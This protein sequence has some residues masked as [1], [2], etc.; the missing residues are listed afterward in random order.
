M[1]TYWLVGTIPSRGGRPRCRRP[2][3]RAASASAARCGRTAAPARARG[4]RRRPRRR[5]RTCPRS[6]MCGSVSTSAKLSTGRDAR[7]GAVEHLGPVVAVV[8][9]ERLGERR[10]QLR[11]AAHVVL[12]GQVGAGPGRARRAAARRTAARS[13]R[14]RRTCRRRFRR[15]RSTGA[16]VSSMLVPRSSVHMPW[17]GSP[18]SSASARWSRRPSR[19]R[20]PGPCRRSAAPTARRGCRRCRNID[21]PPKSPT[22]FSGGT[23]RSPLRPTACSTPLSEM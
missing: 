3:R 17:R 6:V 7:V 14:P 5:G 22:R 15:C 11:P 21:P 20:R 10:P 1:P 16:P 23:G 12:V 8:G 19:R 13:R 2:S 18:T 4:C 9:G